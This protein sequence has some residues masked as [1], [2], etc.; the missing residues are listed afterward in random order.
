MCPRAG[1]DFESII[2]RECGGLETRAVRSPENA[3]FSAK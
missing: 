3:A 1:V 2:R